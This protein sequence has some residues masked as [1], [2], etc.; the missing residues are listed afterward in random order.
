MMEN[1]VDIILITYNSQYFIEGCLNSILQSQNFH[2]KVNIIVIDNNSSDDTL[3]LLKKFPNRIKIITNNTN[4]GFAA[5]CNQGLSITDAEYIFLL[6]PDTILVNDVLKIFIDF[7]EKEN[8][9]NVWCV[10]AQLFIE[11]GKKSKSSGR[12]PNLIDVF[13]EQVGIKRFITKIFDKVT[14]NKRYSKDSISEVPYIMGCDMFIRRNIIERIGL[15][16]ERF[17]LNFEEV[18]LAWRAKKEGYK[19]MLLPDAKIIHY[20]GKSFPD[21]KN[22]FSHL[23]YGQLMFFKVTQ[24]RYRFFIAKVYHLMGGFSRLVI[25][26]DKFYFSHIKKIWSIK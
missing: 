23:W 18:E 6:N 12:F 17:F 26:F 14:N 4:V 8:N 13:M 15:F 5:A 20:S 2:Y 22:S 1:K 7:M 9:K 3:E 21:L 19:C 11:N 25:K 24:N 10:G 16:D